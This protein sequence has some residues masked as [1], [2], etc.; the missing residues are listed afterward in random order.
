LRIHSHRA[1]VLLRGRGLGR[2]GCCVLLTDFLSATFLLSL[3]CCVHSAAH[4][5]VNIKA[6]MLHRAFSVFLF[7]DSGRLLIQKRAS[8]KITFPRC[9]VVHANLGCT[10]LHKPA[11][12]GPAACVATRHYCRRCW[13][14]W[15][16]SIY[17]PV[18]LDLLLL[19]PAVTAAACIVG[20][21]GAVL[22]VVVVSVTTSSLWFVYV[23]VCAVCVSC[24]YWANTCCSHPLYVPEELEAAEHK[25]VIRA[26]RRKLEQE[27][28]I[29]PEEVPES[30]FTFLTR[31]LYVLLPPTHTTPHTQLRTRQTLVARLPW[32]WQQHLCIG[33]ARVSLRAVLVAGWCW[34]AWPAPVCS[35]TKQ[36]LTASGG[37]TRSTTS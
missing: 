22:V 24:S 23:Y 33:L 11:S 5:N 34:I 4:L 28:G 37:S 20:G 31:V 12:V 10:R 26:A 27:L 35:G 13:L 32:C 16:S 3:S 9:V 29:A 14:L 15:A 7:D 17:F 8:T 1:F 30:C 6:G 25:G 19:L 2:G 21:G 18:H 36:S